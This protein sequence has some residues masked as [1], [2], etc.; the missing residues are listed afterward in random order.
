VEIPS[1]ACDNTP[2]RRNRRNIEAVERKLKFPFATPSA[3][4]FKPVA[5]PN[6]PLW[7]KSSPIHASPMHA[8]SETASARVRVHHRHRRQESVVRNPQIPTRPLF[9]AT[10]FTSHSI[11]SYVSV[12]L[13]SLRVFASCSGRSSQIFPLNRTPRYLNTKYI[14]PRTGPRFITSG[15]IPCPRRN[16]IRVRSDDRNASSPWRVNLVVQLH[17]SALI[18]RACRHLRSPAAPLRP[19][20]QLPRPAATPSTQICLRILTFASRSCSSNQTPT[21]FAREHTTPRRT[22]SV[23]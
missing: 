12:S 21:K 14:R 23:A 11:V 19:A 3:R 22:C 16:S 9:F 20:P 15:C 2:S 4:I 8:C 1:F 5:Q 10:F 18:T 17:A 13:T 7:K 6:A